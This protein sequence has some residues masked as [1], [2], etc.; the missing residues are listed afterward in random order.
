MFKKFLTFI[1]F[2]TVLFSQEITLGVVPQQSPLELS[3]KWLKITNYLSQEIG[4][5]VVFRTEKSIQ[6]FEDKLYNGEYDIA[7]M[8][9]YH[10]I[11]ANRKQNYSAFARSKEDIVGIVLGKKEKEFDVNNST[12]AHKKIINFLCI[13][14]L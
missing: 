2:T 8:N 10:F 12:F 14:A 6:V 1:F 13:K 11:I 3:K 9:P 7:Y 5:N 4:V